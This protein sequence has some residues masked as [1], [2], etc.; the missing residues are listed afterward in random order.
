MPTWTLTARWV[1]PVA[2]PPL[3]RGVVTIADDHIVAV[4]PRGSRSADVDAGNC[5]LL[6]G[7]VNTHTHLDLSDL[8]G[9]ISPGGEF[10]D[11]LRAVI[12]HRRTATRDD[13]LAA[14]RL[15]LDECLRSG[16]TLIADVSSQGLSWPILAAA[17]VRATVFLEVL[18]LSQS[19]AM[20]AAAAARSWLGQH[21]ATPTCRPAL[22]PH[23]SYSVRASLFQDLHALANEHGVP[24]MTHLA[25]TTAELELLSNHRGAFVVLLKDLEVWDEFG[26]AENPGA[27]RQSCCAGGVRTILV[28][29]N[30]LDPSS[31][32]PAHV[33]LVYCPRTHAAFGHAPHPFR[34]FLARGVRVALGTDGLSSN[35]DLDVLAEARFLHQLYPDISG[36]VLLRMLT[37]SGAEALGWHEETGSLAPGKS[38]D[39]VALELPGDDRPDPHE[40]VFAS[41]LPV[42][43]VLWCGRWHV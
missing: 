42:Q 23:A 25:E 22:S 3:E 7:F 11:W 30:Y 6:P 33:F 34:D 41:A 32:L 26:L 39:I 13:T 18:G 21:P 35:P 9:K 1:F 10:T 29:G 20:Q 17:N 16:T 8:R 43:R 27:I 19:R 40:L 2:G 4:E 38:A 37:L 31:A 24:L 14:V 36:A 28:H 15:G 5:A 12:Q